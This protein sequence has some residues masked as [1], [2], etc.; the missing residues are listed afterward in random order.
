MPRSWLPLLTALTLALGGVAL[1]SRAAAEP[2]PAAAPA[3]RAAPRAPSADVAEG[4]AAREQQ[5]P[6]EVKRFEGGRVVIVMSTVV[7]VL[8]V[9]LLDILFV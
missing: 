1:P 5:A 3:P 2:A 4:Y 6:D 8:L 9:N 7:A